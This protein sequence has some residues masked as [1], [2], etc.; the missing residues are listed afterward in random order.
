VAGVRELVIAFP[1]K[2]PARRKPD[3]PLFVRVAPQNTFT[4]SFPANGHRSLPVVL[5]P[6]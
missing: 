2:Q 5:R 6:S 1:E 4:S 3:W